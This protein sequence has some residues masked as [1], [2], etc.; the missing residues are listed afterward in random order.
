MKKFLGNLI[1]RFVVAPSSGQH[2]DLLDG[3][4]GLAILMV[5]FC[6]GVFANPQGAGWMNWLAYLASGGHLGVQVFFVLSGFLIAY[7]FCRARAG[8]TAAW[9]VPGY[10]TRRLLKIVPPFYLTIVLLCAGYFWRY[11]D[12]DYVTTGAKWA[13]GIPH[14]FYVAHPFNWS[15]WSLWAEIGFYVLLPLA[16]WLTRGRGMW[17]CAGAFAL[18]LFSVPPVTRALSWPAPGQPGHYMLYLAGR[19]PNALTNFSWGVLFAAIYAANRQDL[20][21]WRRWARLGYIGAALLPG[22]LLLYMVLAHR[23]GNLGLGRVQNEWMLFL[24]GV[25]TF[26]IALLHVRSGLRRQPGSFHA[27]FALY[28]A[29]QLRVVPAAPAGA[30]GIPPLYGQRRRV[31]GPLLP[32][33]VRPDGC[34]VAGGQRHVP[35]LFRAD[36]PV[37]AAP[38]RGLAPAR[39]ARRAGGRP[40]RAAGTVA[41]PRG[42]GAL[43]WW[44]SGLVAEL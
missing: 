10:V 24:S 3:L 8:D 32:D 44:I 12:M 41:A 36:H 42:R 29:H 27:R 37:G 39:P 35:F 7:P 18:L 4:R 43:D 16:F 25:S 17:F 31:A 38:T 22:T 5:V 20:A 23:A 34:L 14:L 26:L 21:R 2:W 6:H 30:L 9:Y 28:R 33:C 1:N 13:V 19:F 15:F 40:G 11:R